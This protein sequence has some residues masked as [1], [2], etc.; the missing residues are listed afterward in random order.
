[1]S[2]LVLTF[3]IT[4]ERIMNRLLSLSFEGKVA[5]WFTTLPHQYINIW[6]ELCQ[7]FIKRFTTDGDDNTFLSLIT[8][9]KR[10]LYEFVDDFNIQ[11]EKT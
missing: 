2:H 5:K 11:F 7:A 6:E 8:C 10:Y 3:N 1:M 9:I 4:N